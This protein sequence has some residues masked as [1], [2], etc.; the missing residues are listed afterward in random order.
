MKRLAAA[1]ALLLVA[2]AASHGD[3]VRPAPNFDFAGTGKS[4]KS[5]RGQTVVLLFAQSAREKH[6]REMVYRLKRLYSQFATERVIF[7][8]AIENGP[9]EV[10]SNIPFVLAA[11]PQKVAADYGVNGRYAIAVIGVDGNVDMITSQL[12]APERV[13]DMVFDNY[14]SQD[15]SRKTLTDQ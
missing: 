15:G 5:F 11:D 13:R 12:I 6:F 7:V 14:E 8:A 1:L 2:C 9:Q 4:L 10:E 3:V